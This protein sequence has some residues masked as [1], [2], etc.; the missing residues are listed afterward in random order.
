MSSIRN[1]IL[2]I[3]CLPLMSACGGGASRPGPLK[4]HLDDMHLARIDIAEK[5]DV[6]Q[7]QQEHS[8]ARMEK[9]K[10]EAE[11]NESK[12]DVSVAKNER[13]QALLDEKTAK[14]KVKAADKSGDMNRVSTATLVQRAAELARKAADK[15]VEYMKARRKYLKKAVLSAEDHMYSVE[16]RYELSKARLA[17]GKNIRPRGFV[18]ADYEKQADERSKYEQR[19]RIKL[20]RMKAKLD[21]LEEEWKAMQQAANNSRVGGGTVTEDVD[22]GGGDQNAPADGSA[23][24]EDGEAPPADDNGQSGGGQ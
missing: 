19:N 11:Y 1:S 17:Q 3:T 2:L 9:A 13:A 20:E 5:Q 23:P 14:T 21:K 6:I 24:P 12:T 18:M 7:S 15:K 16:A 10:A 8:I 4:H 22:A